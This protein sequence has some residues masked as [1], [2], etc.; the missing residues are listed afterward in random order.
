MRKIHAR[1]R[2]Y[3]ALLE[4]YERRNSIETGRFLDLLHPEFNTTGLAKPQSG[5]IAAV[6]D[7]R[8]SRKDVAVNRLYN[9]PAWTLSIA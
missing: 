7:R 5:E 6:E 4:D 1:Y 2:T 8:Q 9:C 3:V